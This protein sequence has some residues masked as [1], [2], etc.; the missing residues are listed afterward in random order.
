[1]N[2]F[3]RAS[4]AAGKYIYPLFIGVI[5]IVCSTLFLAPFWPDLKTEINIRAF[6][7][8]LV[9]G[10][11]WLLLFFAH[12]AWLY[13]RGEP[14]TEDEAKPGH[15]TVPRDYRPNKWLG[16]CILV[17]LALSA[18]WQNGWMQVVCYLLLLPLVVTGW[19]YGWKYKNGTAAKAPASA[20][21]THTNGHKPE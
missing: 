5:L 11:A 16:V 8:V 15:N 2:K 17:P 12:F 1:M 10:M 14:A 19:I 6:F 3:L 18:P 9:L 13:F 4:K 21:S 7:I 20:P